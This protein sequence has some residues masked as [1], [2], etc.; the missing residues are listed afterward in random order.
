MNQTEARK[1][2]LSLMEQHGLGHVP[3]KFDRAVNRLGATRY[4]RQN[5]K[6]TQISLSA[7]LLPHMKEKDVRDVVLHEIAHA[8]ANEAAGCGVGHDWRWRQK[9]REI[10]AN[11]T[12]TSD[13]VPSEIINRM[14]KYV[15]I[16][17][18]DMQTLGYRHRASQ[19]MYSLKCRTHRRTVLVRQA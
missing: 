1:I 8:L 9:C 12:R 2:A 13:A 16:C 15:L 4:N 3:F 6:T 17:P 19:G 10:G 7:T 11:P 5:G 18:V 14:A